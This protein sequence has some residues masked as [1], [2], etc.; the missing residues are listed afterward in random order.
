MCIRDSALYRHVVGMGNGNNIACLVTGDALN[1]PSVLSD[2]NC[3]QATCRVTMKLQRLVC[4]F[5]CSKKHSIKQQ[6]CS[7]EL[8]HARHKDPLTAAQKQD[9]H[10]SPAIIQQHTNCENK[11]LQYKI[12]IEAYR[13]QMP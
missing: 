3:S 5:I 2:P 6:Q 1:R 4:L 10:M 7:A 9:T 8:E 13:C 12:I 11:P